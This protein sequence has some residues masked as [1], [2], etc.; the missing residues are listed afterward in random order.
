MTDKQRKSPRNNLMLLFCAKQ[1]RQQKHDHVTAFKKLKACRLRLL[2]QHFL[3]RVAIAP[4]P[5]P[6]LDSGASSIEKNPPC[7]K[8][9]ASLSFSQARHTA[10][11]FHELT[12][13]RTF[14]TKLLDQCLQSERIDREQERERTLLLLLPTLP[15][16]AEIYGIREAYIFG[17]LA[18]PGRL[19]ARLTSSSWNNILG[20][21]KF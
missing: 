1:R 19:R 8:P 18:K 13:R 10:I 12:M 7:T 15:E 17:S 4:A 9:V 3:I 16:L 11:C 21:K 20:A 6:T 2:S 14:S 5:N